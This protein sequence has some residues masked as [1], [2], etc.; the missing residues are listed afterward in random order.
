MAQKILIVD[1]ETDILE[2]VGYSLR[3]EGYEVH[4]AENGAI[5]LVKANEIVPDLILLDVMMPVMNGIEACAA[6]R[7][8]DRLSQTIIAFLTA[9]S[10]DISEIEG[11]E[12]GAD[13]YIAKPIRPR[14]LISRV[15]ALLRRR[16]TPY[17]ADETQEE[18]IRLGDLL[19]YRERVQVLRVNATGETLDS[20]VLARK[21]F[22]LLHLLASRPGKVF[23]REEIFSVI[24]GSDVIVG[25][26][27]IDVHIRKIREKLGG[28]YVKTVKG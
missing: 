28:D 9:K 11:F 1:D 19:I 12:A 23:S 7:K 21:E 17:L 26:R 6:L 15:Q 14:L 10:D 8:N 27:T 18:V 2:F 5:G 16:P 4:T 24:W 13:D 25:E 3:R 20:I 22:E